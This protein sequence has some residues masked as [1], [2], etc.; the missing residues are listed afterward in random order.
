MTSILTSAGLATVLMCVVLLLARKWISAWIISGIQHEY[1]QKLETHKAQ[2]KAENEIAFLKLKTSAE[3][4][5]ALHTGAHTAFSTRQQATMKKELDAVDALWR[6][7]V[8]IRRDI[9]AIVTYLDVMTVNEYKA[10]KDRRNFQVLLKDTPPE[11]ISSIGGDE[12]EPIENVRPYVGEYL[13]A[14]FYSYKSIVLRRLFLLHFGKDDAAKIEWH[15]DS[16][17]RQV[18]ENILTRK[19]LKEF[20]SSGFRKMVWIQ[21]KL[22]SKILS[23]SA[24]TISGEKSAEESLKQAEL[25]QRHAADM[26]QDNEKMQRDNEMNSTNSTGKRNE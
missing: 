4:E 6:K 22:E 9:P 17:I 20:D 1:D 16:V 14:L 23:S 3:Q 26:Q 25:I 8:A 2:L 21:R 15:K 11:K 24:K 13:W 19:E 10:T 18:I 7:V 12:D 5:V